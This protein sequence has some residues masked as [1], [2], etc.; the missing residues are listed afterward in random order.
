VP[1]ILGGIVGVDIAGHLRLGSPNFMPKFQHTQ[2][3]QFLDTFTW[4]SGKH[5]R[6]IGFDIMAPM[7]NEYMDIPST[8]GNLQFS[9]QFTGNALADF[10][11]GYAARGELSN[12]HVVRQKMWAASAFVQDDWTLTDALTLNLGLRYDFMTPPYEESDRMA[13]FDPNTGTLVFATDG[14][15]E[16]RSLVKPDYDN[17]G[18]RIGAVYRINDRT[19]LRGGYGIFYN[20]FDRVGSEDQLSLN[21]PGL[22]NINVQTASNTT[23]VLFTR[24]GFPIDFLDPRNVNYSRLLI[25]AANP[26]GERAMFQQ[27]LA[28]FERQW[29]RDFVTSIDLTYNKGSNLAVLRNLNQPLAG[30]RDANGALPYPGFA[31]IQWRDPIGKSRYYGSDVT[32]AKRFSQGHSYRLAY[33]YGDSRDQAPEHLAASSGRPQNGRD[34]DSWE[35]PS[36]FD[37]RHR[38][39]GD[40]TADSPFGPGKMWMQNG[41]GGAIL[42]GWSLSGIYSYRTGRPFTVTQGSNNVGAGATGQPNRVG[43]TDG[44]ET[45]DA[46]FN[47]AAFEKVP[48][49]TFGNAGRNTMRGPDWM[50]FDLSLARNFSFGDR[51]VTTLRWDVFNVF[52]RANL[53]LPD[54]NIDSRTFGVISSLAGDPRTMQLSAR[55][56]Y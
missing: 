41:I 4:L 39:V 42:G 37:I 5:Q 53:G 46:W 11:L 1:R 6:K 52:N 55:V 43:Y 24:D 2:Q 29:G 34:L 32:L 23:P 22:L 40:F 31:H 21:P 10:V 45:T 36:D 56:R 7:T 47:T 16:D 33:T 3:Y 14:S 26:S 35:G 27:L 18:P 48:S 17:F 9:G 15:L 51:L 20:Q 8:R 50:T 28:G 30:T 38:V 12:V 19:I 49:G 54:S 44:P 25:R 13:N